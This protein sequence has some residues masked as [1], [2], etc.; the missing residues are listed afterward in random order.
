MGMD[1]YNH[2]YVVVV[3][4]LKCSNSNFSTVKYFFKKKIQSTSDSSSPYTTCSGLI[5]IILI[6]II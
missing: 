2:F 5:F 6:T 4:L 1:T 3:A